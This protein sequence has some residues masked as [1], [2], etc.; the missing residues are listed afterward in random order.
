MN[1]QNF[2]APSKLSQAVSDSASLPISHSPSDF[3]D[4][5]TR[6]AI[7]YLQTVSNILIFYDQFWSFMKFYEV[8]YGRGIPKSNSIRFQSTMTGDIRGC[9]ALCRC[10]QRQWHRNLPG[11]LRRVS[12]VSTIG[13][14]CL[15]WK[16]W[17]TFQKEP[18]Y[19]G[20][21][22]M[23]LDCIWYSW[24]MLTFYVPADPIR[25]TCGKAFFVPSGCPR[26]D[27]WPFVRQFLSLFTVSIPLP[28]TSSQS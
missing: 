10:A 6:N 14:S 3:R 20:I 17:W 26:V 18:H 24:R 8:L 27:A 21:S 28:P 1:L 5:A 23:P 9:A 4:E 13:L 2:R 25:S 7:K 11:K 19:F 16:W 12:T 22:Y 15:A